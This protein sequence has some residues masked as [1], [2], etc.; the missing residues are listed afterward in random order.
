MKKIRAESSHGRAAVL[1]RVKRG[2][3]VT[4][5]ALATKLGVTGMAIRQHLESLK[6]AGLVEC[7]RRRGRR[8]RPSN[9][10]CATEKAN[11]YFANSH[12]ALAIDLINHVREAFGADGLD[13]LIALRTA[14]QE[15]SYLGQISRGKSVLERL[16]RLARI[17]SEEGYM[18]EAREDGPGTW[19]LV[20]NHCPICSAAWACSGI[21][22]EELR[23]FERVLGDDVRVERVSHIQAGATR[24]AY[25]ITP[26]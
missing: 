1:E 11:A 19:L 15:Q 18:A 12:A 10:W 4:A 5:E 7:E 20:E 3:P 8:G 21:C 17:R 13:K 14:Q 26:A 24:C 9:L 2:G 16:D 25:R 6:K 22:R 23:L